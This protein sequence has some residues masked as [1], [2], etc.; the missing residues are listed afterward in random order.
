M[1]KRTRSPNY[2]ALSL[3][4]AVSKIG[5]LYRAQHHHAAPRE[6]IAKGLG[7][8]SL[9]G[10]SATTI[11][12]LHKYGLLERVGDNA[13]VSERAMRIL[14]PYSP[15]DRNA[16]YAEAAATP[17]LFAELQDRF[18]GP[19]PSEELL[20]NYLLR[21]NFAPSAVPSVI[22]AY[23]DTMDL[24]FANPVRQQS[25]AE[26]AEGAPAMPSA[27]TTSPLPPS[28]AKIA[29][30]AQDERS[31]MH[32]AFDGGGHLRV[33]LSGEMDT[34]EALEWLETLITLR[35]KELAKKSGRLAVRNNMGRVRD[36]ED[37]DID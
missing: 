29:P 11:S 24:V 5:L 10:A 7:Y 2:P 19:L 15:E 26:T 27:G 20:R 35:R 18:P 28:S 12:A 23:R 34:E 9:N 1:D 14:A 4:E 13:K 22:R 6:V 3:P 30:L 16:A 33:L 31:L 17:T 21:Q 8:N 32:Y 25:A 37:G 36:D